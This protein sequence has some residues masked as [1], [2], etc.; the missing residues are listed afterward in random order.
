MPNDLVPIYSTISEA[1]ALAKLA[2]LRAAGIPAHI[3]DN[4]QNTLRWQVE[5]IAPRRI[6]VPS[7]KAEEAVEL[8]RYWNQQAHADRLKTDNANDDDRRPYQTWKQVLW[9]I[10]CFIVFPVILLLYPYPAGSIVLGI[11]VLWWVLRRVGIIRR[12]E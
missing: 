12:I 8:I 10:I 5:A 1:E 6:F 4:A 7:S 3:F 2:S 9:R 11:L